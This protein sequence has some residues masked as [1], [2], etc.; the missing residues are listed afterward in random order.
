MWKLALP[1]FR[2]PLRLRAVRSLAGLKVPSIAVGLLSIGMASLGSME[3]ELVAK[4]TTQDVQKIA[5]TSG[6]QGGFVV[7][8]GIQDGK[9]TQALKRNASFQVQGLDRDAKTVAQVRERL[10]REGSVWGYSRRT[11]DWERASLYR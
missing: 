7:H 11:L 4:D 2:G 3:R 10:V 9:L 5:E 1:L 6:V 8:V